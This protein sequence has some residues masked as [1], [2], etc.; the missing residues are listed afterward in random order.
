MN[1]SKTTWLILGIG[2]FVIAVGILGWLYLE[3]RH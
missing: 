2:I 1:I 3:Q